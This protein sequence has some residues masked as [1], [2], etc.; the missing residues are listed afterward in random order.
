MGSM[1]GT[2]SCRMGAAGW[3]GR[4]WDKRQRRRDRLTHQCRRRRTG[5]PAP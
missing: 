5:L 1:S 3:P 4:S 2:G